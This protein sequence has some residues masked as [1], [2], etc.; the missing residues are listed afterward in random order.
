MGRDNEE[1]KKR[2]QGLH[3]ELC[4]QP[5]GEQRTETVETKKTGHG[6][7]ARR[8]EYQRREAQKRNRGRP[9]EIDTTVA[10]VPSSARSSPSLG[11]DSS[12]EKSEEKGA[13]SAE[14]APEDPEEIGNRKRSKRSPE[15]P[16]PN[17]RDASQAI[18]WLEMLEKLQEECQKKG[19][20]S[21][22]YELNMFVNY[23]NDEKSKMSDVDVETIKAKTRAI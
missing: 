12:K 5:E 9:E 13:P 8:A 4:H 10:L 18:K 11:E 7:E 21:L 2:D 20:A 16:P 22:I 15:P 23:V 17:V 19:V 1:E 14:D 3:R 6:E